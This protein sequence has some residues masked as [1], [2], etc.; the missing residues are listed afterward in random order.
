MICTL[1]CLYIYIYI[2]KRDVFLFECAKKLNK[3]PT[4]QGLNLSATSQLSKIK[5]KN[6]I[7]LFNSMNLFII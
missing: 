7:I 3:I 4:H 6:N 2:D 5:P 1:S